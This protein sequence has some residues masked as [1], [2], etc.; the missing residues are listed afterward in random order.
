MAQKRQGWKRAR[1]E[2]EGKVQ[3]RAQSLCACCSFLLGDSYRCTS[4]L[5]WLKQALISPGLNT[6][7]KKEILVCFVCLLSQTVS[8]SRQGPHPCALNNELLNECGY[9]NKDHTTRRGYLPYPSA[10]RK[11]WGEFVCATIKVGVKEYNQETQPQAVV[12]RA[13][14]KYNCVMNRKRAWIKGLFVT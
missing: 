9:I 12:F 4:G 13:H 2:D 11:D 8:S 10:A 5:P 6:S 3:D 14:G 7:H 1:T